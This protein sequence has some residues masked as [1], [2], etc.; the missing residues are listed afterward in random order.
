MLNL[1]IHWYSF[2]LSILRIRGLSTS[3][4][5]KT[6]L[7]PTKKKINFK[8]NYNGESYINFYLIS[9]LNLLKLKKGRIDQTK[10]KQTTRS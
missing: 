1:L 8:L 5:I 7:S 2:K 10:V 9:D 4:R 3:I 6:H